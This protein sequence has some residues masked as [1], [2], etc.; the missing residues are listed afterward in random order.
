MKVLDI[1]ERQAE[2]HRYKY[3]SYF[4]LENFFEYEQ[5]DSE[6]IVRGRMKANI[7]FWKYISAPE[8]ITDCI[9]QEYKIPFTETGEHMTMLV[10]GERCSP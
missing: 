1:S 10:G 5:G 4:Y 8:E 3:D 9:D 2:S 7:E 6:P